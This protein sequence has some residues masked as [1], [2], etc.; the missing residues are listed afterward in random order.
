VSLRV[1]TPFEKIV[2]LISLPELFGFWSMENGV[3]R[4]EY[5]EWSIENGVLRMEY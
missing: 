1:L 5:G 2:H 3:L 4:M